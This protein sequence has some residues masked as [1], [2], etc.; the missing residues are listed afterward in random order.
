[1]SISM[2][3]PLII[4]PRPLISMQRSP[5]M[6][7]RTMAQ[8]TPRMIIICGGKGQRS[9]GGSLFWGGVGPAPSQ[10]GFGHPS[11]GGGGG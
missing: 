9:A 1:M 2:P 11:F 4:M 5:M 6:M 3:R 10:N 7:M 8:M